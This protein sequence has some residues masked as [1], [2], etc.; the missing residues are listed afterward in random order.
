MP[1]IAWSPAL[2]GVPTTPEGRDEVVMVSWGSVTVME[3]GLTLIEQVIGS[4]AGLK[5]L[6]L[7]EMLAVPAPTESK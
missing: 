3:L 7:A 6:P 4:P 5:K 1:F 2:Y